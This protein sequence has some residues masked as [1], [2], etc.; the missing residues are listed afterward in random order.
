MQE[1][2]ARIQQE[3]ESVEIKYDQKRKALKELE[4]NAQQS[5]SQFE[6]EKAV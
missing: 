4:K 6:R 1:R 3:K 2:I 5:H